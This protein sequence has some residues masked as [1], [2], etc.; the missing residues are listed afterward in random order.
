VSDRIGRR[1]QMLAIAWLLATPASAITI[2]QVDDFQ[3]GTL[4]GW[5]GGSSYAN[6]ASGG[7]A[8]AG[9]RYL[10]IDSLGF[11]LGAFNTAQWSGDYAAAGVASVSFDLDNFGPDTVSLR[12]MIFTPGCAGGAGAC[13][14]W[15]S[16]NATVL[17]S[18]SG[19][20]TSSFSLT[21]AEMTR[22]LGTDS[23]ITTL[24]NVER[25]LIRHD[26]GAPSPPGGTVPVVDAVLGVDNVMPEPSAL[27]GLVAGVLLLAG[28]WRQGHRGSCRSLVG[29]RGLARE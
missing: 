23:F 27:A 14:A 15:T 25:L 4:Q 13:T 5:G 6:R 10:E 7:P 21:E 9:D 20:L 29:I 24:Q 26:D 16:T 17:T 22:V 19:W 28:L 11:A 2:G 12:I 3:D 1:I 8:G 18:G